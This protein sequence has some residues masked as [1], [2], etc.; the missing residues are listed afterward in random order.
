MAHSF[1]NVPGNKIPRSTFDRSH[2]LTTA[3]DADFLI[4]V[5]IDE[6]MPGDVFNC[7]MNFIC[8]L[9]TPSF[10]I[11][12]NLFLDSFF[13]FVPYRLLWSNWTHFMGAQDDPGDSIAFTIP[14][15][16]LDTDLS[17]CHGKMADYMQIPL[18][19]YNTSNYTCS[20]LPF[21]A[22]YKIW[23]DWFRD[24]NL[25]DN[26]FKNGLANG[27]GPN[28]DDLLNDD[29]LKRG[30]RHDYFTSCQISLQKG[31]AVELPLGEDAVVKYYAAADCS[32]ATM[33]WRLANDTLPAGAPTSI[34]YGADSVLEGGVA[35]GFVDPNG[36]LYADLSAATASTVNEIRQAFQVQRFLEQSQRSGTRY[37]EIIE[38][39]YGIPNAGGDARLQRSEYLGGGST[40]ININPVAVTS[41]S[42]NFEA[43]ELSAIGVAHGKHGFINTFTEHGIILGLVNVRHDIKYQCEGFERFWHRSTRYDFYAPAFAH[44]GEMAVLDREI[45]IDDATI[46]AGTDDDVFGYQMVWD[47]LRYK[48]SKITGLFRSNAAAPLDAFH[49]T[50]EFGSTPTLNDAFIRS[51]A[52]E[53]LDRT[54]QTPTEPHFFFDSYFKYICTRPM[55]VFSIPGFI[56]HL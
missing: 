47:D 45:F 54:L 48:T 42:G 30:K 31:D 51:N 28:N 15:I 33:K 16:T 25:Q 41:D 43:G 7:E 56:D 21:R 50:E 55:P 8:R 12:A 34:D 22:Y 19:D 1:A 3:F 2:G 38:N 23:D 49:L 37:T 17:A 9:S 29:P 35:D 36:R 53:G 32:S 13:F 46:T 5:L 40:P 4:P 10:P 26:T 52:A 20:A 44:L 14:Q 27:D 24:E 18:I 6:V 11:M 39:I